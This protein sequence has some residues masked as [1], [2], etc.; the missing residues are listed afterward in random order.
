MY[1]LLRSLGYSGEFSNTAM[2][3]LFESSCFFT[4]SSAFGGVSVLDSSHSNRCIAVSH[5]N[6]NYLMTYN[7]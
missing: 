1:I 5:F 7:V 2:Q 4:P 3:F 6:A